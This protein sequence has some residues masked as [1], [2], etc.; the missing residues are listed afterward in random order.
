MAGGETG[1]W[2]DEF[3][4]QL[5]DGSGVGVA[6][7][8]GTSYAYNSVNGFR[9][10]NSDT[11]GANRPYI[12]LYDATPSSNTYCSFDFRIASGS[13]FDSTY[14]PKQFLIF[15]NTAA[16]AGVIASLLITPVTLT[17]LFG[18]VVEYRIDIRPQSG[19]DVS[20]TTYLRVATFYR[21]EVLLAYVSSSSQNVSVRINDLT[22]HTTVSAGVANPTAGLLSIIFGPKWITGGKSIQTHWD[23]IRVNN[24]TTNSNVTGGSSDNTSWLSE[25]YIL[26]LLPTSSTIFEWSKDSGSAGSN[27]NYQLVDD[28]SGYVKRVSTSTVGSA[29][30]PY[31]SY[32]RTEEYTL[33]DPLQA[34]FPVTPNAVI[35]CIG[36]G[37]VFGSTSNTN[38]VNRRIIARIREMTVDSNTAANQT[39]SINNNY[40]FGSSATNGQDISTNGTGLNYDDSNIQKGGDRPGS[41]ALLSS[42]YYNG[43]TWVPWTVNTLRQARVGF[44]GES[45]STVEIRI[46]YVYLV[47]DW[48]PARGS[49]GALSSVG[50]GT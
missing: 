23:N 19:A 16:D 17:G 8:V 9:F 11:G 48:K 30:A 24:N 5:I 29:G 6:V 46:S 10:M 2:Q 14:T 1:I 37:G 34:S 45:S 35:N 3:T 41:P 50:A 36:V 43:T 15:S 39:T 47:V 26:H 49:S 7:D 27:T 33:A 25:G 4:G 31:G 21:I 38:S 44:S 18:E 28:I 42:R 20:G 13:W 32:Y 12:Q 40:A 22:E